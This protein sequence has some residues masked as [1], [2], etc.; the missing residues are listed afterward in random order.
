MNF[1]NQASSQQSRQASGM[2]LSAMLSVSSLHALNSLPMAL[3]KH[4][5]G[6]CVSEAMCPSWQGAGVKVGGIVTIPRTK[7]LWL[8][9]LVR[10]AHF[11]HCCFAGTR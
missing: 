10:S 3:R 9:K 7:L 8:N 6:Q 11:F 2:D 4:W 5:F 1:T